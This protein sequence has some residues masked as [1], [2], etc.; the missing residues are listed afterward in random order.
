M[1]LLLIPHLL[2]YVL[3]PFGLYVLLPGSIATLAI[4]RS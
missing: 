3:A 2:T 4:L 1:D